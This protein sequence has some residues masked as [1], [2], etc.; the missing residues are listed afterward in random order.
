MTCLRILQDGSS[1]IDLLMSSILK[2][3]ILS[4]QIMTFNKLRTEFLSDDDHQPSHDDQ[5]SKSSSQRD[6]RDDNSIEHST[7]N[8]QR[9][10]FS[11]KP[12]KLSRHEKKQNPEDN[13]SSS[14][15]SSDQSRSDDYRPSGKKK[16][17]KPHFES[18]ITSVTMSSVASL[19]EE[20]FYKLNQNL[21]LLEHELNSMP[22]STTTFTSNELRYIV[23]PGSIPD[24]FNSSNDKM[25]SIEELMDDL[26][27]RRDEARSVIRLAQ[28]AQKEYVDSKRSDKQFEVGDLVLLKFKRF[29]LG[30]K[31]P[32]IHSNK[33][34]PT[35]TPVRIV[36]KISSLTYKVTLSAGS[37]IHDVVSIIHL[38][39]YGNDSDDVRP[40][41][42]EQ[43]GQSEWEV[44]SIGGESIVGNKIKEYLLKW[45]AYGDN[46]RT[47]EPVEN[48]F[49]GGLGHVFENLSIDGR[50]QF[51][52]RRKIVR[53]FPRFVCLHYLYYRKFLPSPSIL[54]TRSK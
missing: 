21:S 38:K 8:E 15:S 14:S 10:L 50:D 46:E 22:K 29:G 3:S 48:E 18:S 25:I 42:I 17:P 7:S 51:G 32:K 45:V 41:P 23:P 47:W 36:R 5:P 34:G 13:P 12:L 1:S 33:L 20:S 2:I 43:D 9:Y 24:I 4:F 37:K 35:C 30:Y 44:E 54:F 52:K 39:K 27:N 31:S 16:S 19:V 6:K 49:I 11:K 26:K 53:I 28:K 40:L